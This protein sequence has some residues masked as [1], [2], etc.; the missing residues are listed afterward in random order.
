MRDIPTYATWFDLKAWIGSL[1]YK[2]VPK[3]ESLNRVAYVGKGMRNGY[4]YV[5]MCDGSDIKECVALMNSKAFMG[6]PPKVEVLSD[7]HAQSVW[8]EASG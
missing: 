5:R 1:L 2:S 4:A 6:I 3:H 7:E 8:S